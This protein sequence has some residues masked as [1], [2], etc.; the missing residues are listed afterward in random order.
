VVGLTSYVTRGHLARAVLEA[1]AW[2]T[3]EVVE[4]MNAD[5][6]TPLSFLA[7]DGGMTANNVE[8][9]LLARP[10][11]PQRALAPRSGVALDDGSR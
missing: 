7:V 8:R 1:T 9:R 5:A 11:A 4:A 3:K 6:G 10:R 2:Q